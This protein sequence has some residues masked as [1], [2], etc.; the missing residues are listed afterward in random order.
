MAIKSKLIGL[1]L[2]ILGVLPFLLKITAINNFFESYK[3]LS[4][5][6]PGEVV[7]QVA[8]IILGAILIWRVKPRFESAK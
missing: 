7:Y 6:T 8:I 3:F 5:L 2:I 4:Y 1:L